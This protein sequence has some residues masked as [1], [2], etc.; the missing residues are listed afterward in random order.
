MPRPLIEKPSN[1]LEDNPLFRLA[2]NFL[3]GASA[4][5]HPRR[6]V[7]DVLKKEVELQH[8]SSGATRETGDGVRGDAKSGQGRVRF[9]PVITFSK[10]LI[11]HL[12]LCFADAGI[13]SRPFCGP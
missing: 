2:S 11:S 3:R 4:S 7:R 12:S 1:T 6:L 5:L 9:S 10:L 8:S 13:V